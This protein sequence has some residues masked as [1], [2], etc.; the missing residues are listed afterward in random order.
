MKQQPQKTPI[1]FVDKTG[2][3]TPFNGRMDTTLSGW[4]IYSEEDLQAVLAQQRDLEN[5]RVVNDRE[6]IGTHYAIDDVDIENATGE[7]IADDDT[8]AWAAKIFGKENVAPYLQIGKE[9]GVEAPAA[10]VTQTVTVDH[11]HQTSNN[12]DLTPEEIAE[13]QGGAPN[14]AALA[15]QVLGN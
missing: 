8:P 10:V 3:V 12:V 7:T 15:A 2:Y 5:N 9:G 11:L 6:V 1:A 14:P 13:L 4:Y